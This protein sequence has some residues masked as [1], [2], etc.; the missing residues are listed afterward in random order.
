MVDR[1]S[2]WLPSP[3]LFPPKAAGG[4]G[5]FRTARNTL[6]ASSERSLNNRVLC[7]NGMPA[8]SL[9]PMNPWKVAKNIH[10][11]SVPTQTKS[12]TDA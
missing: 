10:G 6:L 12:E 4:E 3:P 5:E 9:N 8:G 11:I 7:A 1:A 2:C